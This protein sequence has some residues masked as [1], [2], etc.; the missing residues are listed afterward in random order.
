MSSSFELLSSSG[1][2]NV[3]FNHDMRERN[4]NVMGV[5]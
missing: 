5:F 2:D 1:R 3:I 4:N